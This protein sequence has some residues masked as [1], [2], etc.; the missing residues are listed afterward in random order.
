MSLVTWSALDAIAGDD[1]RAFRDLVSPYLRELH[2]HCYRMLGSLTD[3]EDVLQEVLLAAWQGLDGFAGRSS[4]RTWLYRIATNRCLNAIRDGKR[5]PPSEPQPPF[6]APPPSRRAEVTWLHPYPDAWLDELSDNAQPA[7]RY[8]QREAVELA[9]VFALQQLPPRQVATLLLCDVLGYSTTETAAM[10]RTTPTATK[11]YLQRARAAVRQDPHTVLEPARVTES[12]GSSAKTLARRFAE[13]YVAA[14][15]ERVVALLTDDAWLT[16]PPATHDYR[17][18]AAIASFLR[19]S[20]LRP[21]VRTS[22][23]RPTFANNQPAFGWFL[24]NP[25]SGERNP[26][27]L[28]VLTIRGRHISGITRFHNPRLPRVFGLN[29]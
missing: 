14:D 18:P 10:L 13:A 12:P 11:G 27:G 28:I 21:D 5:Q 3:A 9:F 24:D 7:A 17:G 23:L 4:V 25:R 22:T 8:A 1:R 20:L 19:A 29:D 15:V 26:V 6:D 2:V 16:M